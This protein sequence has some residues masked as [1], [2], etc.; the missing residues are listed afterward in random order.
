MD[1]LRRML[2][3][4]KAGMKYAGIPSFCTANGLVIEACLKQALRFDDC[5]LIEATANQVN[6][7]GGY[8]G[9]NAFDFADYVKGVAEECAVPWDQV[10]L[11]GDH[12]GPLP[13][14]NLPEEEAMAGAEAMVRQYVLAGYKKIHIDT[15]MRVAS[16]DPDKPC[17]TRTCAQRGAGDPYGDQPP[18][19]GTFRHLPSRRPS[20]AIQAATRDTDAMRI[21]YQIF[22]NRGRISYAP[23]CPLSLP[24]SRSAHARPLLDKDRPAT[25]LLDT[26]R[27]IALPAQHHARHL[28]LRL[29]QLAAPKRIGSERPLERPVLRRVLQL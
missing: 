24:K 9:M 16:D 4:R 18:S 6:Q 26:R 23:R 20:S 3:N 22:R 14:V 25:D 5:V 12:L 27:A 2:N 10:I 21:S 13:F 7:F 15:S 11:G 28:Y 29:L 1:A 19:D 8:T 17:L